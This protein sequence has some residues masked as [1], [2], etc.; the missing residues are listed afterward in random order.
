MVTLK[1]AGHATFTAHAGASSATST[2]STID[3]LAARSVS[4]GGFHTCALGVDSKAYCWGLNMYG[5]L[6]VPLISESTVPLPV[7][8]GL[9][10]KAVSVHAHD[11]CALALD[12]SAYCWGLNSDGQLGNGNYLTQS[13]PSPVAGGLHFAAVSVGGYHACG[14]TADGKIYCW[15]AN[16]YGQLGVGGGT[17]GS[18]VPL[19]VS[20]PGVTFTSVSAGS[21]HTCATATGGIAYCWGDNS[22]AQVG[23]STTLTRSVP[24]LVARH[25]AFTSVTSG[26][27]HSCGTVASGGVYCWGSDSNGQLGDGAT[28]F[29]R[30]APVAV[31][32][33][34]SFT[35][36]EGRGGFHSCA[37]AAAGK[38]YCW[39]EN[40]A[41][42]LGEGSHTSYSIPVPVTTGLS[43]ASI[44][45]GN[46]STCGVTA[47]GSVY[48]WG[49]NVSAQ[50]GNGSKT[51]TAVPV[52]V[53]RTLP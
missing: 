22:E 40:V 16:G 20:A 23:D 39:G 34:F 53:G 2:L 6:G 5:Q 14:L 28:G 10:F 48:C 3:A 17:S 32:G 13:A 21:L 47:L 33:G 46:R 29:A 49:S 50:I 51:D 7:S 9:S 38:P 19:L 41:G 36:A 18:S 12:G 11:T 1:A 24:T 37:L 42:Q 27:R 26:N 35:A 15:G 43:F 4:I 31:T 45:T 52:R 44:A 30:V 25:L 8:G